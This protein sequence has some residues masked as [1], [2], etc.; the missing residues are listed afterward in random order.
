MLHRETMREGHSF[1]MQT[2]L[3]LYRPDLCFTGTAE[4]YFK[5]CPSTALPKTPRG[6]VWSLPWYSTDWE[7]WFNLCVGGPKDLWYVSLKSKNWTSQNRFALK[8]KCTVLVL[9]PSDRE[10][11]RFVT[12]WQGQD[13]ALSQIWWPELDLLLSCTARVSDV[14][15]DRRSYRTRPVSD[16]KIGLLQLQ[17]QLLKFL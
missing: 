2:K 7:I 10:L 5:L 3:I 15:W 16:Q 9:P 12:K 11:W 4:A 13:R 8:Q 1:E 6:A 14:V 17:L